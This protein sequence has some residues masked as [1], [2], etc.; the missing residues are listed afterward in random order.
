MERVIGRYEGEEGGPLLVCLGGM[1]GNEWAGIEALEIVFQLL[2][3]EPQINPHFRFKGRIVGLRGN[4]QAIAE[5]KR[6][7]NRDLNRMWTTE[8]IRRSRSKPYD[9]LE[10]EERELIGILDAVAQEAADYQPEKFVLLDLHTT[11][12]QGGIFSIPTDDA[13]SLRIAMELHAPVIKG[14]LRGVRGTTLHFFNRDLYA[15]ETIAVCFES[16]QHDDPLSVNRAIAAITNCMR[17]I[18]CVQAEDVENRHD[19]LLQEYSRNLPKVAE[20]ILSHAISPGDQFRMMPGFKNFQRVRKGQLLAQD[21][22]GPIY[23]PADGCVLM[24]L[25]QEQGEDGFF[26]V[27]PVAAPAV[28]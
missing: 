2:A 28:V 17:T 16:G 22:Y 6:F 11:T 24:P 25:Y 14:L 10:A 5:K 8:Q 12:A 3:Q 18:G 21:R 26:L 20:L 9:Q 19:E 7:I 1:H 13:D 23:A 27:R 4:L 15:P